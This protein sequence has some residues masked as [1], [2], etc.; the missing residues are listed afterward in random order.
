[1]VRTQIQLTSEQSRKLKRIAERKGISVAEVIRRSIDIAM[2][3]EEIPDRDEM[4]K[5]ARSVFGK[6]SDIVTDVSENH[7]SYLSEAFSQ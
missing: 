6:Y 4:K 5:R 3:S 7:D 1:M 2:I